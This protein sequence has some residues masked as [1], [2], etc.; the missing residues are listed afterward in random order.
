MQERKSDQKWREAVGAYHARLILASEV[1]EAKAE[2]IRPVAVGDVLHPPAE[3]F[4]LDPPGANASRVLGARH[5]AQSVHSALKRKNSGMEP[6][7][8]Q[9]SR[10]EPISL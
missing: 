9:V 5:V 2:R 7:S 1:V 6:G 8:D 10:Q 3:I 4:S